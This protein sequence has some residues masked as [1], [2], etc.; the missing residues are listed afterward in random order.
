MQVRMWEQK[1]LGFP[2]T[3]RN[4]GNVDLARAERRFAM[5]ERLDEIRLPAEAVSGEK[6]YSRDSKG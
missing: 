1:I 3:R 5:T 4:V 6:F 2:I